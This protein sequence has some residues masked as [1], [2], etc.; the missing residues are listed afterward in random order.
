MPRT[1]CCK[2]HAQ[3]ASHIARPWQESFLQNC[4]TQGLPTSCSPPWAKLV[5]EP[6]L[7]QHAFHRHAR[8]IDAADTRGQ[9]RQAKQPRPTAFWL[10]CAT[11]GCD[12]KHNCARRQ[13]HVRHT[14]RPVH[15]KTCARH[16]SAAR[17]LC[18]CGVPWHT[19]P[20]HRAE[21]FAC[22]SPRKPPKPKHALPPPKRR[23]TPLGGILEAL[24]GLYHPRSYCCAP[25]AKP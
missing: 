1:C 9:L 8:F 15:C 6:I 14:W 13:L 10:S 17:W 2:Y 18:T 4:H 19:C 7:V 22:G 3:H 20:I 11:T 16:Y 21:G 23:T 24:D 25:S 12:F 5:G